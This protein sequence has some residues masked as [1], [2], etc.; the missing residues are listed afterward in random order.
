MT[1]RIFHSICAVAITVLL[2]SLVLIMGV[3]YSYFTNVQMEQLG[4]QAVLAA[5]GVESEGLAYLNSLAD[6][7]CRV[8]WI[9]A[10]GNVLFD[11]KASNA[12]ME[13]HLERE[14]I[15]EALANGS[16]ESTRYSATMMERQLYSALRLA[17]GTVLRVSDTQSTWWSLTLAMLQP[18]LVVVALAVG[19]SLFLAYRLS[20]NIVQP[21]NRL[22]LDEPDTEGVYEELSPL[23]ERIDSQQ[24]QLRRQEAALE[25]RKNEFESVTRNMTE[26]L[27]LLNEHGTILS[28]NDSASR[29]LGISRYCMGKDLLLFHNSFEMQELLRT[30]QSGRHTEMTIPLSEGSYQIHASPVI[31]GQTVSGIALLILDI[32]EKEKAE[33]M[34]REFTANVSHELKTPLQSISGCAELLSSG[35]VKA[36]DVPR[37]SGQ[38]FSESKWMISLVEDIIRLSHLDEGAGDMQR[39]ETDLYELA[40]ATV[41]KLKPVADA[42]HVTVV[43][44]GGPARMSGIPQ[45]LRDI[46]FNLC[47]NAIK[48]NRPGGSVSVRVETREKQVWLS[49]RDT[50]IGIPAEQQERIFERFYRVDKSR[51]K[52]VGGTGLGL[53]I[54]KHAARL[55]QAEIALK[56]TLG[57][58]TEITVVFPQ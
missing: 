14:E 48:Y 13:N 17:D 33:Q 19:F 23:L 37:F 57:K 39:E 45:L 46:V 11:N 29:L 47:D 1:K 6:G 36:E 56:S 10:E 49:V 43:L 7:E 18:I 28:I 4:K 52:A 3:L 16:G 22:N 9:D 31:S 58:G 15:K 34:R 50:G 26:G 40:A 55:H 44:S 2:A 5:N 30:A 35:M 42:A 20:R 27:V 53:S 21:L 51:S 12:E 24:R 38:I 54:V 25:R 41:Q 32:T 8:T